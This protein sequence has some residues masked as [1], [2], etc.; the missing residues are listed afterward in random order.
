M[1]HNKIYSS[2]LLTG[3]AFSLPDFLY[4]GLGE[5]YQEGKG[6][7]DES[8]SCNLQGATLG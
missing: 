7:R 6:K 3:F 1:R 5:K 4:A 8:D 2:L